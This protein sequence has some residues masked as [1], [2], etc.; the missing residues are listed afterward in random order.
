MI[1][2]KNGGESE[3]TENVIVCQK[4]LPESIEDNLSLETELYE[5]SHD[6]AD[7]IHC[8]SCFKFFLEYWVEVYDEGWKYWVEIDDKERTE[9]YKIDIKDYPK[10]EIIKMIENKKDVIC[11][12]PSDEY[13]IQKGSECRLNGP[14]W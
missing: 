10:D 4:C 11:K 6:Y 14:P 2:I 1:D 12:N 5:E 9:L 13:I 3:E 7:I 8:D